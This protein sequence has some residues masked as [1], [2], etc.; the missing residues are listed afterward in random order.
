M[1][2]E[3]LSVGIDIGTTTTSMIVSKLGMQNTAA[4]HMVPEINITKKEI[5]YRSELYQTPLKTREVLDGEKIR[6]II[7][8]EYRNA[9]ITPEMVDTG[10]VIITGESS[11]KENAQI[12][13]DSISSLAGEFVVATAGPDL[14]SILAGRGSGAEEFSKKY[15]C[16]AANLDIGGGTTNISVF[17]CGALVGQTCLDVGGRIMKYDE[18]G[19]ISYVSPRLNDLCALR[20]IRFEEGS[21][22]SDDELL[23]VGLLLAQTIFDSINLEH[24]ELTQI[25]TTRTSSPLNIK[26]QIEYISFSG[27]V[28]DCYYSDENNLRRFFD[29]GPAI[30]KSLQKQKIFES[31]EIVEPKETIRATVV[32]AGTYMTEVSGST[33]SY[34]ENVFPIKNL[35]MYKANEQEEMDLYL[36]QSE[37]L[38]KGLRWY[39][40]Q[41][42]EERIGICIKGKEMASYK[43]LCNMA[44]ALLDLDAAVLNHEY[45]L[46]IICE[47]DLAKA[48]GLV[49]GRINKERTIICLDRVSVRSGDYID[50]GAPV[51]DGVA[52]PV[53]VK[54]LIFS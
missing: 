24:T 18:S 23:E 50:I 17:D 51:M 39:I 32:G 15:G 37:R 27:G 20:G 35:P 9:G 40:D 25:A 30:A 29:L 52:L 41:S 53:V 3:I 47:N 7:E 6:Q 19:I 21:R 42:Q 22:I 28:S 13:V 16:I 31:Y 43:E 34:N 49:I 14:E 45:P 5:I 2:K 44:A 48:L 1:K 12:V 38:Q 11:L 26:E 4:S 33:I 10:A 36:G 46:V 54:T 8:K